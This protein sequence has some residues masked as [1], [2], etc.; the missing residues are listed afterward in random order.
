[1]LRRE[2]DIFLDD[3]SLEDLSRTLKIK[4]VVSPNDGY[5]LLNVVLGSDY[6]V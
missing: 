4:I 6:I 2:G 3:V 1:M 5:E